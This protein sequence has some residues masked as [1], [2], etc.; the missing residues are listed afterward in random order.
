MEEINKMKH[1]QVIRAAISN[2]K[3]NSVSHIENILKNE[4]GRNSSNAAT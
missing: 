2:K 3:R 1:G 4:R